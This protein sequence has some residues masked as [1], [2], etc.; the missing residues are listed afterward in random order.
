LSTR[1]SKANIRTTS[2]EVLKIRARADLTIRVLS[3]QPNLKIIG[4]RSSK[5]HIPC[6]QK[7]ATEWKFQIH[8]HLLGM[9]G[10]LFM[11]LIRL[12]GMSKGHQ[13][14]FVELMLTNQ[15]LGITA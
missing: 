4:F 15:T 9:S 6:A 5:A 3:W 12:I 11:S 1:R 2:L 13:L 7:H 10:E 14:H 8:Q